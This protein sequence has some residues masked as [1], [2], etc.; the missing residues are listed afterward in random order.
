MQPS[1]RQ[2][3][4]TSRRVNWRMEDLIGDA[5]RFDFSKPLLPESFARTNA[6]PFLTPTEQLTLNHVR[7]HSYL[8]MFQLVEAFILP[9]VVTQSTMNQADDPFRT[10]ALRQFASEEVKHIEL[11][12]AFRRDFA[13]QFGVECDVIGPADEISHAVLAHSPLAVAILVLGIEWMS[14]GHFVESIRDNLELD[15]QF[16]SLLKYHFMEEVQHAKLDALMLQAMAKRSS[17]ADIERAMDEYFEMGAFLDAGLRQQAA[18]DLAS[19]ERAARCTLSIQQRAQF[20]EV[21]H[22]ALRWTFLGSAMRNQNFLGTLG[23]LSAHARERVESSAALY[24]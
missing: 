9:F 24:C 4:E 13:E 10:P 21:Q 7:A 15:A 19:F 6:L 3:L 5:K 23:A 8:A 18:L 1:Y 12:N 22:Q 16:T 2:L 17:A 11:F 14:Q 20:L